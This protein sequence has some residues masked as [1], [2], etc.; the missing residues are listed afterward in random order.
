MNLLYR[1]LPITNEQGKN[2]LYEKRSTQN[3][4]MAK[5]PRPCELSEWAG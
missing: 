2:Y 1:T 4:D 5:S 3:Y